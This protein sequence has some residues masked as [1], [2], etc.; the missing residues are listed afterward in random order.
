MKKNLK[1]AMALMA[2]F[3]MVASLALA[4]EVRAD[5]WEGA[6]KA[7][8]LE[9]E[10]QYMHSGDDYEREMYAGVFDSYMQYAPGRRRAGRH[11]GRQ[12]HLHAQ[13]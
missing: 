1:C 9:G 8:T 13:R 4:G 12:S 10:I 3:A 7:A 6:E 5:D 2:A 11:P